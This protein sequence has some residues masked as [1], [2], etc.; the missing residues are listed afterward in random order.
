V[1]EVVTLPNS[2]IDNDAL[3]VDLAR[4]AEGSLTEKQVRR[5]HKLL[6]EGDWEKMSTDEALCDR[7]EDEKIRRVYSGEAKKE[8]AQKMVVAAP[9]VMNS[10]MMDEK[11]S[12]KHKID[13]AKTLDSFAANGSQAG[14]PDASRFVI[15]IFLGTDASGNEVVEHFNKPLAVG[16]E[17]VPAIIKKDS[18]NGEPE[19]I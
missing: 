13:A 16:T 5:R 14:T 4:Y 17:D 8:L 15:S 11:A 3:V 1:G 18:D 7:I 10:I 12:P 9:A 19:H 2:F 6:S